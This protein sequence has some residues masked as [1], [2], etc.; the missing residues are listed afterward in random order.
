MEMS[1]KS[2]YTD[3]EFLFGRL[4]VDPVERLEQL[5]VQNVLARLVVIR[6]QEVLDRR[7]AVLVQR[8]DD[9]LRLLAHLAGCM[10]Q[11]HRAELH[12][13]LQR[14]PTET[15]NKQCSITAEPSVRKNLDV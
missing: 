8:H 2:R 9:L 10:R 14:Q 3:P 6:R 15:P 1:H 12:H 7:P 13:V 4:P 5:F 11:R